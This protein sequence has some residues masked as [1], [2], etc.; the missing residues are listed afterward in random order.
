ML[1]LWLGTLAV[2]RQLWTAA[3]R[4]PIAGSSMSYAFCRTQYFL[5]CAAL[6]FS[7]S[8]LFLRE[9]GW[10]GQHIIKVNMPESPNVASGAGKREALHFSLSRPQHQ[11]AW[12]H[13]EIF[14][15]F[16]C[17][18]PTRI[19]LDAFHEVLDE[20]LCPKYVQTFLVPG[21]HIL[22]RFPS[23]VNTQPRL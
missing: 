5:F 1:R 15:S 4:Q 23:A 7:L 12:F 20:F 14:G 9:H 8:P 16:S 22:D 17:G 13:L 3:C 21:V 6:L 11:S 19:L 10:P 18:Q 2:C